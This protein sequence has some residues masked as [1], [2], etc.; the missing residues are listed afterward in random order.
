[1]IAENRSD[2]ARGSARRQAARLSPRYRIGLAVAAALAG[3]S[4]PRAPALADAAATEASGGTQG[5]QE[6]VVTARKVAENLQ[7]VPESIDV[8]TQKDLQ[9]LA[10]N[11]MDDYLQKVQSISYIST[12]PGTQLFVMRGVSDG[13]NPNY[14]NTSSTGFF[15]DDISMSYGGAQPDLHLYDV[16]RIEVL[17]G[18]QGTTFG[19]GAMSGAIRY[20]T[21]KPDLNSFGAGADFDG[22][23][24]QNAQ[25]NWTYEGFLNLPLAPGV[26][27][28]RLSG[29]SAS[30]GGFINN[31]LVT[32]TWVNGAVSNNSLWARDDYNRENVE[33]GRAE[34]KAQVNEGWSALLTYAFQRQ[35]T[36]GAW[37][38]LPNLPPRTVDRFGPEANLFETNMVEFRVDGDVGIGDLVYIGSYWNQERRQVN[39]YSQY[40]E[41]YNAGA[42]NSPP[43]GYPGTQEGYT[44]L[45][46]P[47]Y[48]TGPFTGCKPAT[49]Y[50]EYNI[51]PEQ[52]SNE[53]RLSSK[54]G[55]RFHWLAGFFWQRVTDKNFDDPYFMPGL[56]YN[57]AAF[58]SAL[59]YYGLTKATLPPGVWYT[60]TETSHVLQ[61]TEFANINFDVTDKL[62]VEAGVVHFHDNE[63][64]DTPILGF[65]YAP[66]TPSDYSQ[67][68]HKVDG[69][70]GVSYK[71]SK[72]AM[73]YADWGQGFRPGGSN[74]G[75]PNG[76]YTSGVPQTYTPDT[77]NNYEV[78]WKTTFPRYQLLW[79]GAAY[80]MDW[81][82]LQALIY[83]AL[84]CPT[85]SYNINVGE[86][87]I[88]GA[89]SNVDYHLG[90][91]WAFQASV[92]YTQASVVDVIN[93][94]YEAYLGERLPFAPYFSWSWNVRYEQPLSD[95]LRGYAQFDIAHKGDM[96]NGLNPN[97]VNTGLPRI[98]QP[99][100]SIMNL[101]LGLNSA[102]GQWLTEFYITNLA[103]KNAI[104]YSN[105]GNFDLRLTTNEPRVYGLR[106]S[107]RWGKAGGG[108]E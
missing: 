60:Y 1:M 24:I 43:T 95:R 48:G 85:S 2:A 46:D 97:D 104:I 9:N 36:L 79:N 15:V 13:S 99:S 22:G 64:Y 96:Y 68:S 42:R 35:H 80:Y 57:G 91:R 101:R 61:T 37:D 50:Y 45:N 30:S 78:G 83:N 103:D 41:N 100:Y 20:I 82:D 77:L 87:H 76:C 7:I 32:R 67:S 58:Q 69:K 72:N 14:A 16:E 89:E 19:A 52:Y 66:N 28:L 107:Y 12:G 86:A 74:T 47:Y 84:V 49:Q 21:N 51:N 25:Q 92:N 65:A 81:K 54:P 44:C 23:Q 73:L 70:A 10:I 106:V 27:G 53:L 11:N 33:G 94:S 71:L 108:A 6:V 4:L 102:N 40:E 63:R 18:P 17:N 98:L 56:Q 39:E 62:N 88:Y 3:A 93:P 26:L 105:T 5:L 34:L 31:E 90:E 55:G 8:F 59:A 75:D 38:E 29:Y